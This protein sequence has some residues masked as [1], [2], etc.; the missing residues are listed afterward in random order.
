MLHIIIHPTISQFS[1]TSAATSSKDTHSGK[2][3]ARY[4][5]GI[6]A[7]SG[8]PLYQAGIPIF[9]GILIPAGYSGS[10]FQNTWRIR[11]GIREYQAGTRVS[12]FC[13]ASC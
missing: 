11:V 8:I 7:T 2:K 9:F 6:P 12:V 13:D 1:Y 4:S 10:V 5:I 3:P